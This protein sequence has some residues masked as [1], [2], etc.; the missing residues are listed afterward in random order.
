MTHPAVAA[1]L[2][3]LPGV[4]IAKAVMRDRGRYYHDY[5]VILLR[6]G[7]SR[8]A[9]NATAMHEAIHAERGDTPCATPWH[10]A[11]QE[12]AVDIEA[13]R[14]LIP[15]ESLVDGLL[16]STWEPELADVLDVDVE[17]VRC[18]L[19]HLTEA[20]TADIERRFAAKE[21]GAA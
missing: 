2:E 15:I 8:G 16:W 19:K 5:Q 3:R 12:L 20:E 13:A 18:R 7:L 10:E 11:K 17:T 4:S 14:R 6:R 21:E 1:V 9:W